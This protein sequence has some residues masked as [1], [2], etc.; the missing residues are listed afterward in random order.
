MQFSKIAVF[1]TLSLTL[2]FS[3][4]I[5]AETKYPIYRGHGV[6]NI[7]LD[8]KSSLGESYTKLSIHSGSLIQNAIWENQL[9]LRD[10]IYDALGGYKIS[11]TLLDNE[12]LN[13]N[14]Y[15][16]YRPSFQ[17]QRIVRILNNYRSISDN[18]ELKTQ[19]M[20]SNAMNFHNEVWIG[21]HL[22]NLTSVDVMN[23]K[24]SISVQKVNFVNSL[25]D[26]NDN[27]P[28]TLLSHYIDNS[29]NF[30]DYVKAQEK[31]QSRIFFKGFFDPYRIGK[32]FVTI[33]TQKIKTDPFF[34]NGD[35]IIRRHSRKY[36]PGVSLSKGLAELGYHVHSHQHVAVGVKKESDQHY[37]VKIELDEGFGH[38]MSFNVGI[39]V[40]SY[41]PHRTRSER[42]TKIIS[43]VLYRFDLTNPEAI[44][45][46]DNVLSTYENVL[47]P[48]QYYAGLVAKINEVPGV[49]DQLLETR[50]SSLQPKQKFTSKTELGFFAHRRLKSH[51]VNSKTAY[52]NDNEPQRHVLGETQRFKS[53]RVRL[54]SFESSE[55]SR[56]RFRILTQ[57]LTKGYKTDLGF[58][59]AFDDSRTSEREYNT[60]LT[61]IRRGLFLDTHVNG[62]EA[63]KLKEIL[64]QR[65]QDKTKSKDQQS[66][67][68]SIYFSQNFVRKVVS[69]SQQEFQAVLAQLILGAGHDWADLKKIGI[70]NGPEDCRSRLDKEFVNILLG[71][72][73]ISCIRALNLANEI[74]N[75]FTTAKRSKDYENVALSIANLVKDHDMRPYIPM[76]ML[77][78]GLL[79]GFN[80]DNLPV[81][82][83]LD[84]AFEKG[85]VEMN[86]A[87]VGKGIRGTI[88]EQVG[89]VISLTPYEYSSD[90]S[91]DTPASSTPII[92]R[93]EMATDRQKLFLQF[94]SLAQA[95]EGYI[96]RG[97]VSKYRMIRNDTPQALVEA[98]DLRS[99]EM[100]GDNNKVAFFRSTVEIPLIQELQ[101]RE[102]SI[103]QFWIEDDSGTRVT[104]PFSIKFKL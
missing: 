79:E 40:I 41:K 30:D 39:P 44:R 11:G 71:G 61:I 76:L 2:V 86:L 52:P 74:V 25:Q 8:N 20:V 98:K 7:N 17:P 100:Y 51:E 9:N 3:L 31:E 91:L 84:E 45:Q 12:L 49:V 60:Y 34:R 78:V 1:V 43:E 29:K 50:Q 32:R 24:T 82:S 22:T 36:G 14:L 48:S 47:T 77:K 96:L 64:D 69:K 10:E 92:I 63:Q 99:Q 73:R 83:K 53:T 89:E 37:L 81:F 4:S 16:R 102:D 28:E 104:E 88:Y 56:R 67:S 46:L 97:V 35:V 23:A 80:K 95:N 21:S 42:K 85:E 13:D 18:E 38:E 55:D 75:T 19:Y 103:L 59:Y 62:T 33:N 70:N 65:L 101:R 66:A 90:F 5:N 94:D 58:E 68:A 27:K 54:V 6:E 26:Y 72:G 93:A 57:K 15:F 87:F